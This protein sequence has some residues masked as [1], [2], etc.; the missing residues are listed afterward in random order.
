MSDR[1]PGPTGDAPSGPMGDVQDKALPKTA[2]VTKKREDVE[3][4]PPI[5]WSR[6]EGLDMP[7]Y[8]QTPDAIFDWVMAYLT[9]AE[10]KILL[11]I[12]RRTF[13]FKKAEDAISIDQ[14]CNGII[15]RD[16]R[17]LDLG[18]GLKR[19]TVLEGVR[20]LREK[21]LIITRQQT[22]IDTGSR[23]TLYSLNLRQERVSQAILGNLPRAGPSIPRGVL[24][25]TPGYGRAAAGGL[26]QQTPGVCPAIPTT[27]S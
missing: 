16:G 8:T 3:Q 21:K 23:P 11:Y 27:D 10:L 19:P 1:R 15:T 13:G 2:G 17:R 7:N 5:D 14:L 22:D 12:I 24:G 4:P 26:S 20:A 18:T 9:G 25:H 6:F